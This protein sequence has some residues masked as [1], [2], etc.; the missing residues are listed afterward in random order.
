MPGAALR[1]LVKWMGWPMLIVEGSSVCSC[2]VE[3][4]VWRGRV[5]SL[6]KRGISRICWMRHESACRTGRQRYIS[7]VSRRDHQR[8]GTDGV[9]P[10]CCHPQGPQLAQPVTGQT[11][12]EK[13]ERGVGEME[14]AVRQRSSGT[15]EGC[16]R[17]NMLAPFAHRRPPMA[18]ARPIQQAARSLRDGRREALDASRRHGRAREQLILAVGPGRGRDPRLLRAMVHLSPLGVARRRCSSRRPRCKPLLQQG[19]YSESTSRHA[20]R[21]HRPASR[22]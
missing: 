19:R 20:L 6:G 3:I 18:T 4:K 16:R 1:D 2:R 5:T 17:C 11:H 22:G 21:S 8:L 10:E 12:T 14:T 7:R 15:M 9:S 13:I